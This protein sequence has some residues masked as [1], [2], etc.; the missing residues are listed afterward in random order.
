MIV[1]G[2]DVDAAIARTILSESFPRAAAEQPLRLA[3]TLDFVDARIRGTSTVVRLGVRASAFAVGALVRLRG[4][5]LRTAEP[6]E[7]ARA[8][9]PWLDLPLPVLAE[10][11]RLV[12]SLTLVAWYDAPAS[13]HA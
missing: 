2:G 6:A 10:Y 4:V 8:L 9:R 13:V 3:W 7:A 12:R 11:T 1:R 5:D